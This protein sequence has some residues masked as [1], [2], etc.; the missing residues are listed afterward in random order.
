[1][2]SYT[3]DDYKKNG[4]K[5]SNKL[6]DLYS[7][8]DI[9]VKIQRPVKNKKINELKFLKNSNLVT[10]VYENKFKK[11]GHGKKR[12]TKVRE[13]PPRHATNTIFANRRSRGL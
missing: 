7:K 5:I 10:L 8:A 3:N 2:S 12:S 11:K 6:T 13:L 1:M 4:A 9:I